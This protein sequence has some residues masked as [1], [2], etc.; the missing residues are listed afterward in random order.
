MQG[1]FGKRAGILDRRFRIGKIGFGFHGG[2]INVGLEWMPEQAQGWMLEQA[3]EWKSLTP[4]V[5]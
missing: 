1:V 4:R 3:R 5:P 2:K